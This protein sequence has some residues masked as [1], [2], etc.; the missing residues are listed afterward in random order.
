MINKDTQHTSIIFNPFLR[1]CISSFT[2]MQHITEQVQRRGI[3]LGCLMPLSTIFQ[4]YHDGQFYW[5][6]KPEDQRKY[7]LIINIQNTYK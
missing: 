1:K 5:W 3:W 2:E 6:R 4:L 7:T